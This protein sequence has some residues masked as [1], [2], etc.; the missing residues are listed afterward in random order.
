MNSIQCWSLRLF[1]YSAMLFTVQ[2]ASPFVLRIQTTN[3]PPNSVLLDWNSQAGLNYQVLAATNIEP[4]SLWTPAS[5]TIPATGTNTAAVGSATNE[6]AFF[7]MHTLGQTNTGRPTV[8]IVSHTNGE[9]ASGLTRIAVSAQDDSRIASVSLLVDGRPYEASIAEGDLYWS[10][11]T[12]HFA[13]GPHTLQA[14]VVDNAGNAALGGNPNSPVGGNSTLSATVTLNFSNIVRWIDPGTGFD[15]IVP[16][17]I[18]SSVFPTNWTV[19]VEDEARD[20]IRTFTGFTADGVVET[21]WDGKD[22]NGVDAPMEH[23]YRVLFVLG[24]LPPP[25]SP[26]PPSQP[27]PAPGPGSSSMQSLESAPK[28][29]GH[30]KYGSP[31]YEVTT[32]L[33]PIPGVYFDEKIQEEIKQGKRPPLPPLIEGTFS[34]NAKH[35][36]LKKKQVSLLEASFMALQMA[37]DPNVFTNDVLVWRETPWQSG[38]I[39]LARQRFGGVGLVLNAV[40]ANNLATLASDIAVAEDENP[41]RTVYGSPMECNVSAHY[42]VLLNDLKSPNGANVRDFYYIGHST[43]DAI[44]YSEGSPNNGI[45]SVKLKLALR[46]SVVRNSPA[47]NGRMV[48]NFRYPYRFVFIDGCLSVNGPLHDA[49]GIIDYQPSLRRWNPRRAFL[50]WTAELKNSLVNQTQA[51]WSGIFWKKW[52]DNDNANYDVPLNTAIVMATLAKPIPVQPKIIGDVGLRWSD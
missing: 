41:G 23:A 27:G 21:E 38:Q 2:G 15:S 19:Y 46:N 16:I 28:L 20:I 24:E 22:G 12:G 42:D 49:F 29:A 7:K 35:P 25:P 48:L 47:W 31:V 33:P 13:N 44:G 5:G 4:F 52:I 9:T 8:S 50:G 1:A 37:G 45:T 43:G 3:Q 34:P 26:A 32:P 10:V 36:T 14:Q 39:I 18:R 11:N 6:M 30:N 51:D 17:S 40:F